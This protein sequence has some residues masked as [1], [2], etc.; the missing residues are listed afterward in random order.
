MTPTNVV[1][2]TRSLV[3]AIATLTITSCANTQ[4]PG[5]YWW[6]STIE[7]S[8]ESSILDIS[9]D[10]KIAL[11]FHEFDTIMSPYSD[12]DW[13]VQN[14]DSVELWDLSTGRLIRSLGVRARGI[15]DAGF[16]PDG[17]FVA[18][19][20]NDFDRDLVT[21]K[22]IELATDRPVL[23]LQQRSA[24]R[25]LP[26]TFNRD[27]T[28]L[29][30][31]TPA[32][33]LVSIWDVPTGRLLQRFNA[34]TH[35]ISSIQFSPDG[36]MVASN[37]STNAIDLWSVTTGR[38][39]RSIVG[40]QGYVVTFAFSPDGSILASA[41]D[42]YKVEKV[43]RLYDVATG[44]Q[45]RT[46]EEE[47]PY[48]RALGFSADGRWMAAGSSS[49]AIGIWDAGTFDLMS[50]STGHRDTVTSIAFSSDGRRLASMGYS[51]VR[52]WDPTTGRPL[53]S[54][55][56]LTGIW[57]N[58]GPVT[59][60]FGPD[61]RSLI[62][63]TAY[64]THVVDSETGKQ[65]AGIFTS[66]SSWVVVATDGRFDATDDAGEFLRWEFGE[67]IIPFEVFR[68]RYYR[69]GLLRLLLGYE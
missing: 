31:V 65:L 60:T 40:R 64:Q 59:M 6:K 49:G 52:V 2:I 19:V 33:S 9:P 29:A 11:V 20:G 22:L 44:S 57:W 62:I 21:L 48:V 41:E 66:D 43:V 30:T 23:T 26:F 55:D 38:K 45:L 53:R 14:H 37:A 28:M 17:R 13:R 67:Q 25:A 39:V 8:G 15:W 47:I 35:Y 12:P 42:G 7:Y 32:D 4:R 69:K 68:E 58:D 27:G 3:I 18:Y 16:S 61:N 10:G 51:V 46:L 5:L 34:N 54:M 50:M 63:P 36:S 56:D 1:S 24:V